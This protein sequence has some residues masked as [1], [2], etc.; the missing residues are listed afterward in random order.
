MY[1][2]RSIPNLLSL[3]K[4]SAISILYD[5]WQKRPIRN[6][7]PCKIEVGNGIVLCC[8]CNSQIRHSSSL[9]VWG[10]KSAWVKLSLKGLSIEW[11]SYGSTQE[12]NSSFSTM[13]KWT[14]FQ[15]TCD[16][17]DLFFIRLCL[18]NTCAS[19][20][21]IVALCPFYTDLSSLTSQQDRALT[22]R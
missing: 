9:S 16:F 19:Q 5:R 14:G 18:F 12:C 6:G 8:H 11:V 13:S 22:E 21:L 17:F 2:C 15:L 7:I 1:E 20:F 10:V 3:V 4:D